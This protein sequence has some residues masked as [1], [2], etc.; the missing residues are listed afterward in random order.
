MAENAV[1]TRPDQAPATNQGQRPFLRPRYSVHPGAESYSV[2]VYLP[3]VPKENVELNLDQKVLSVHAQRRDAAPEGWRSRYR[4]IP[5]ADY[6]LR[7]DLNVPIAEEKVSAKTEHGVLTITLPI[8]EA[9]K[10]RQI[11]VE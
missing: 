6:R 7:L 1:A 11:T 4:E 2:K 8:A 5:T 9:A 3:G 10:P